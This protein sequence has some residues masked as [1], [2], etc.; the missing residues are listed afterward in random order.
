MVTDL[1]YVENVVGLVGN[2]VENAGIEK[3]SVYGIVHGSS[4]NTESA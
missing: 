4:G 3:G 1:Q 2:H